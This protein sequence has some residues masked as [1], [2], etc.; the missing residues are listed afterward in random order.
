MFFRNVGIY[1]PT[2]PQGVATQETKHG[3]LRSHAEMKMCKECCS[4]LRSNEFRIFCTKSEVR[5]NDVAAAA[6]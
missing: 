5:A 2:S 6:I 1:A 3:N 4:L